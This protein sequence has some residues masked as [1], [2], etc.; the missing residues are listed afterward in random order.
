MKK[1]KSVIFIKDNL[2]WDSLLH[3]NRQF[4]MLLSGI[5][6]ILE[7]FMLFLYYFNELFG[8]PIIP[9]YYIYIYVSA[10]IFSAAYFGISIIA[11]K[12]EGVLQGSQNLFLTFLLLWGAFFAAFDVCTGRSSY[13]FAVI[14]IF[15]CEGVRTNSVYHCMLNLLSFL[16]YTICLA[17]MPVDRTTMWAEILNSFLL[18]L[19]ACAIVK[20]TYHSE[21]ASV[22]IVLRKS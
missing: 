18:F 11:R 8:L 7:C 22:V 4:L 1:L 9:F 12:N 16:I 21:T 13:I 14:M 10:I 6:F 5:C 19:M 17:I 2:F 20:L 3:K 15:C